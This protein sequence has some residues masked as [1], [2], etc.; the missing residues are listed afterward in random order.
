MS[1]VFDASL[2][3]G[4]VPWV[5]ATVGAVGGVFLVA[6]RSR[7]WWMV[8]LPLVALGAAG[9]TALIAFV[10]DRVWQP[11][12]DPLP[13]TV[14]LAVWA[15]LVAVALAVAGMARRPVVGRVTTVIAVVAVLAALAQSVNGFYREYPTLRTAFGLPAADQVPFTDVPLREP[16]V[17][18]H[19]GRPFDVAWHAPDGMPDTGVVTQ[20][21]IPATRSG[22]QARPAWIYLPPAYLTSPRAQLPVLILLSG[23][24]GSPQDWFDSGE[25]AARMD[26]FAA[27][28]DG[29]AP[30][31]VV[32]DQLGSPL[33][34]P[35]CMDSRLGEVATYL[36]VDVPAWIRQTLQVDPD[37]AGWA[38]GGLSNGGTCS[39]QMA[40]TAP[41]D[42]PTIVDI[43]GEAEPSLGDHARTVQAAFGGDEAEF[44][45]VNPL[46]V[47][48]SRRFP[49][50]AAY[51]V[52]G[53]DDTMYLAAAQRVFA[54]SRDAGM[55]VE[56]HV[57]PGGHTWQVWGPGLEDALPW[58]ATRLGLTS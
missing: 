52:A 41:E 13:G 51:L 58:L 26:R 46:Q 18:V 32:P 21:D 24:P 9:L 56:L 34:N 27:Q 19:S 31:V 42:F 25:L 47:L 49:N 28:H 33:A 11:F 38:I 35:L 5:L 10:V 57:L 55:A 43:S 37:P 40:V 44:A 54:V 45:A 1:S 16:L 23:Q 7:R 29:L 12:P 30:V 4:P 48:A 15:L 36:A 3:D 39:L 14:L 6:A 8:L 53:R 22:F 17:P 20:V 50:T 2:L